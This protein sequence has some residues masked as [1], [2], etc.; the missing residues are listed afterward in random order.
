MPEAELIIRGASLLDGT[1]APARTADVS[2]RAGR[3][4]DLG[5]LGRRARRIV[6]ADGLALMPGIVDP[7][8][9][10]D[11][12][13][14][15]DRTLS[16]SPALGVTTALLGN[17]GFGIA[18]CPQSQRDAMLKNISVRDRTSLEPL[19]EDMRWEFESFGGYLAQLRRVRP[20][21]N[22]CV[23]AGHSAIRSAVMGD[24]ASA[25]AVP[26][27]EELALMQAMVREALD[28]GAIG[29]ASSF[30]AEHEG[31]DGRPMPSTLAA[32]DE[33]RALA[34]PL[35]EKRRGV[36]AIAAGARVDGDLVAAIAADTGRPAFAVEDCGGYGPGAGLHQLERES[37]GAS[38]EEGVRCLTSA[39]ADRYRIP[40]RGRIAPGAWADLL[41]FEPGRL[42]VGGVWV[43]GVQVHD[44]RDF[45]QLDAGPGQVLTEFLA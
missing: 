31:W 1:G 22:V 12:Q 26:A 33:L 7:H 45:L 18:P 10:A 36:F 38:L 28:D 5:R 37:R 40:D 15:W 19:R 35:G 3:I 24:E 8:S 20:Y 25:R 41:L 16:P 2:V 13:L 23:F 39:A 9:R 29:F 11:A 6:D 30:S 27:E 21:A 42:G 17:C 43:N 32:E 4:E 44:G 34:R 14:T